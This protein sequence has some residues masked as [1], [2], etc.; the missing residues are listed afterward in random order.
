MFKPAIDMEAS[1]GTREI[2]HY[3]HWDVTGRLPLKFW[4]PATKT[5]QIKS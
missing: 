3:R 5:V 2:T 4:I 1:A